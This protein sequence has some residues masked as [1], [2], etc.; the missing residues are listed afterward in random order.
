MRIR[1]RKPTNKKALDSS[2]IIQSD[3]VESSRNKE[4]INTSTTNS[5]YNLPCLMMW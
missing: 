2:N 1:P 5:V 4:E 3:A